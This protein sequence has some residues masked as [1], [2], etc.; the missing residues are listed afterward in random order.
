M[1]RAQ[2]KTDEILSQIAAYG[3]YGGD[4]TR[5]QCS[6]VLLTECVLWSSPRDEVPDP[7][8]DAEDLG[9][10]WGCYVRAVC[11]SLAGDGEPSPIEVNGQE[12]VAS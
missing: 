2:A 8:L 6:R 12:V 9:V 7:P 3:E 10:D 5:A 1:T 11:D 4:Y